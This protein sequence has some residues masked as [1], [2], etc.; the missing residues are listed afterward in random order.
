MTKTF[1]KMDEIILVTERK[2]LFTTEELL[3]Q[4]VL[5]AK[6]N[7]E[8]VNSIVNNL[9]SNISTMRRGDAEE[10]VTYK[11]PI[12]YAVIKKGDSYFGYT[13]LSG[14][15]ETRLHGS[16]SLGVGGHMNVIEGLDNF[17]EL[18]LENLNRELNEELEIDSEKLEIKVVGLINDD[19][20]E[21]GRVHIGLLATIELSEDAKVEVAETDQLEGKWYSINE[22]KENYE[23]LES[24]SK[25]VVDA[26]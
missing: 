20:N 23:R 2:Q 26:L 17:N 3:F 22:L 1:N 21:V 7:P 9:S 4:G 13:R 19:K 12:P 5:N 15:G 11:Q 10:D 16:I 8:T 14:G 6:D 24:W 25:F 18:L